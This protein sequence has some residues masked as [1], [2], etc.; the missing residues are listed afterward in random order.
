MVELNKSEE[1]IYAAICALIRQIKDIDVTNGD[2]NVFDEP[3]ALAP[4]ELAYICWQLSHSFKVD[5]EQIVSNISTYSI[6]ELAHLI[7]IHCSSI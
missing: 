1:K 6:N 7:A 4:R 3:Y 5:W 2:V